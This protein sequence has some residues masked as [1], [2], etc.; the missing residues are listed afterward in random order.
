[1][2]G[3]VSANTSA[4]LLAAGQGTRIEGTT[5]EPKVLLD[6]HGQSLL[7]RHLASAT[8]AQRQ[9]RAAFLS[10]TVAQRQARV[11]FPS[12]QWLRCRTRVFLHVL[13]PRNACSVVKCA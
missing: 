2:G 7:E 4:I 8:V 3:S 11:A 9:A 12:A 5:D 10:A 6:L 1:M 13:W